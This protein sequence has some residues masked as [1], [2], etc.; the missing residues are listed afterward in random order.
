MYCNKKELIKMKPYKPFEAFGLCIDSSKHA[1]SRRISIRNLPNVPSLIEKEIRLYVLEDCNDHHREAAIKN[2]HIRS[3]DVNNFSYADQNT[4]M[5]PLLKQ[6]DMPA[7]TVHPS[8]LRLFKYT[9]SA[10]SR[11]MLIRPFGSKHPPQS[12]I[13]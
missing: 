5:P 4:V 8:G 6:M 13:T 12:G 1:D 7:N 2:I 10:Q 9:E 11:R 3:N